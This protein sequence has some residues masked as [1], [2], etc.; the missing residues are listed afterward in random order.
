MPA[1]VSH[2]Q[3][4]W[5]AEQVDWH[6]SKVL[7]ADHS[8]WRVLNAG[9]TYS[10]CF[11]QKVNYSSFS[12]CCCALCCIEEHDS[13]IQRCVLTTGDLLILRPLLPDVPTASTAWENFAAQ[14]SHIGVCSMQK[15]TVL[16]TIK[17]TLS[18]RRGRTCLKGSKSELELQNLPHKPVLPSWCHLETLAKTALD[19]VCTILY[20]SSYCLCQAS[21]VISHPLLQPALQSWAEGLLSAAFHWQD[22]SERLEQSEHTENE[23]HKSVQSGKVMKG[24]F[25]VLPTFNR[26]Q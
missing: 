14:P 19:S 5:A 18:S 25:M 13:D 2:L 23:W 10:S 24:N 1:E 20:C 8:S 12:Q 3:E 9:G 26:G 11:L 17:P 4:K 15:H 7:L 21:M 16:D 6:K 22:E